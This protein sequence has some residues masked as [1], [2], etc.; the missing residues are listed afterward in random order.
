[1]PAKSY[2]PGGVTAVAQATRVARST[3]GA[4]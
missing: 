3:M 1:M 2:G 4:A